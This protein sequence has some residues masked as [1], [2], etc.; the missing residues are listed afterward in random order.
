MRL[1]G[2][3]GEWSELYTLL[4]L[5]ETGRL[6]A[7]DDKLQIIDDIYFP[8]LKIFRDGEDGSGNEKVTYE[9]CEPQKKVSLY[10][11]DEKVTELAQSELGR[12]ARL[13]LWAIKAGGDRAFKIQGADKIME[14]LHCAKI[15]APGSE[16]A[17]I[18]VQI[19][20]A[21]TGYKP[22][23]GF[24]IKSDLGSAPTLLNAS[25]ATNFA[26]ECSGISDAEAAEIN[27]IA[28]R[29]KILD[30]MEKIG[31]RMK[32]A[33]VNN[34]VFENNLL[35]VDSLMEDIVAEMLL[36]YYRGEASSLSDLASLLE[37]RN[38]LGV[39][40]KG[41]YTYKLRKLLSAVALGMVPSK[42]WSGKD[43]ANGGYIIVC[44]NGECLAYH[45]YN[46]DQFEQYLLNNTKLER[47][48]TTRH[49]FAVIY[50]VEGKRF[51][52]LNLQIRF[53]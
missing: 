26:Y 31:A 36:Y 34:S 18:V 21:N 42:P 44:K 9:V 13:L 4:R 45:I 41:Y 46:R 3:K 17:D 15:K 19:H 48:S 51:V 47:G 27:A 35:L 16:K 40:K 22:V 38:P 11:G 2:N 12:D 30:R 52:N 49:K 6:Y 50:E 43:E 28:T 32:Y 14:R 5:L 39:K 10:V 24:S 23:V 29:N 20:D 25:E 33:R 1:T 7:A 53:K 8:V 37:K